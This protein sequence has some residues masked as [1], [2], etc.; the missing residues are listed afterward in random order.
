[1]NHPTL[2]PFFIA[3]I[4][5]AAALIVVWGGLQ[6]YGRWH[7]DWSGYTASITV[8]DGWCNIAVLPIVGD[9]LAYAGANKDGLTVESD[10]PPS[11][12]PDDVEFMLGQAEANPYVLG[13]LVRIDSPGGSPIGGEMIANA[14]KRSS[15]P[16]A[17]VVG[18]IAASSGYLIASGADTIIASP[19]SDVGS[20][21]VT[22]SYLEYSQQNETDGLNFVSLASG[23][24]KDYM[25]PDKPL[26]AGERALLERDLKVWH[27]YFV[28]LV[29]TN[30]DLPVE[31]VT[32]LADGSS[33]P[34]ALALEN[35]LIDA[36]GDKQTARLWF[37]HELGIPVQDVVFCE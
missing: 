12:N 17:A 16:S 4:T 26:T 5:A 35:G 19:F 15:L 1:M 28:G 21:G 10:L 23:E 27:D 36:L 22:M 29:A 9:V 7:D 32:A 34:G 24:F 25:N 8:S 13:L 30:R 20:I 18:D 2:R 31:Q 37:A 14:I 11:T 6:I 33:M 3:L